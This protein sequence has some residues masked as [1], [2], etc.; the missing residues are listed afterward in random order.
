M[1]QHLL[2]LLAFQVLLP[3]TGGALTP[4]GGVLLTSWLA[5]GQ[6]WG[7]VS[8]VLGVLR[9]FLWVLQ[10]GSSRVLPG[11]LGEL[12]RRLTPAPALALS[13]P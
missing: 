6:G 8:L 2:Q 4:T 10:P 3:K 9:K 13:S 1:P 5:E 7:W 11:R 12:P